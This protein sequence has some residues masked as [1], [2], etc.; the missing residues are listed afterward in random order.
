LGGIVEIK[1]S[2]FT[3]FSTCGAVIRNKRVI[4]D[5]AP[6]T[7]PTTFVDTFQARTERMTTESY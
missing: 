6:A 1:N 5:K 3:E 4:L 2:E 7:A